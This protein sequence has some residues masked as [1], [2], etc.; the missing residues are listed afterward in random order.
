MTMPPVLQSLGR[1]FLLPTSWCFEAGDKDVGA[2]VTY[3]AATA[4]FGITVLVREAW[5]Q[6]Q[7]LPSD[8]RRQLRIHAFARD[9]ARQTHV[10]SINVHERGVDAH[11]TLYE[12]WK[13]TGVDSVV[14]AKL[15]TQTATACALI[16]ACRRIETEELSD[17]AFVCEH[18]THRSVGCMLLLAMFVYNGAEV[19]FSTRRTSLAAVSAGLIEA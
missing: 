16:D 2:Y 1:Q 10:A 14:Q 15:V 6:L 7:S 18:G 13:V 4:G 12:P 5:L 8:R 9:V 3:L 19:V 17:F 11:C